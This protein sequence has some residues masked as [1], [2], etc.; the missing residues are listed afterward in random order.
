VLKCLDG[1]K[2][3]CDPSNWELLDRAMLP[4]L[5]GINGLGYDTAPAETKPA[6]M[7]IAKIQQ[8]LKEIE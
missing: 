4:R 1:D 8:K 3:N 5:N 7:A 6:I 2:Q